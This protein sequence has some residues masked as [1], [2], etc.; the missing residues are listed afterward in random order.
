MRSEYA[1]YREHVRIPC[2]RP[3]EAMRTLA[4]AREPVEWH[5]P[6]IVCSSLAGG[7][8]PRVGPRAHLQP[9][10]I[11]VARR[12][13][14]SVLDVANME[15]G[16]CAG[17][18]TG[19]TSFVYTQPEAGSADETPSPVA[20]LSSAGSSRAGSARRAGSATRSARSAR[21]SSP[22]RGSNRSIGL[23]S[24]SLVLRPPWP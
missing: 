7:G 2:R 16:G 18:P 17:R 19:V 8:A 3:G 13:G 6:E 21:G 14:R 23:C 22:V 20:W 5:E 1:A 4:A 15:K 9:P 10:L 12:D 11:A 24:E